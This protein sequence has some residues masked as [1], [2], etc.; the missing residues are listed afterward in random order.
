MNHR[1]PVQAL[2]IAISIGAGGIAKGDESTPPEPQTQNGITFLNGGIGE[3]QV[4]AMRLEAKNGYNLQLVFAT[5]KSGQYKA[6]V[7]VTITNAKGE[8][9]VGAD[10]VG[11]GFYAKLPAGRYKISAEAN[12][13]V[14]NKSIDVTDHSLNRYVLY[15][16]AEP[17][18]MAADAH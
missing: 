5:K 18:E 15:W 8:K 17:G 2:L 12:G 1:K 14:Q 16:A 3:Q 13:T 7:N 6:N 4:E 10:S 9:L 11:P